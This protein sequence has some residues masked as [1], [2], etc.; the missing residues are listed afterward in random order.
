MRVPFGTGGARPK[1]WLRSTTYVIAVVAT[2]AF[3]AACGSDDGDDSGDSKGSS[4][5]SVDA[6]AL[7]AADWSVPGGDAGQSFHSTLDEIS[8]T[9]V[10]DLKGDWKAD[11][12]SGTEA[13]FSHETNINAIDGKLYVTTGENDV[14][15]YDGKTGKQLWKVEGNLDP[16]IST[17]CCGWE[18]RGLG[19][20]G[21]DTLYTARIDGKVQALDLETGDVKW[22]QQVVDW[23]KDNATLIGAPLYY[24]GK[25]YVG[26]SGSEFQARGRLVALDAKT[27]DEEWTF[28]TTGDGKD[29][30]ADKTWEGDS[31]LIGGSGLWNKPSVDEELGLLIFGTSTSSPDV[32]GSERG[33]DNLYSNSIVAVDAETGKYKWH[34]QLVKHDIWDF[35]VSSPVV[36]FDAEID[37]ETVPAAA[38]APKMPWVYAVDRRTG[39]PIFPGELTDVPQSAENKT[40]KQ[41]WVPTTE[42]LMPLKITDTQF[43]AL[44]DQIRQSTA[45]KNAA[46]IKINRP[47]GT[48]AATVFPAHDTTTATVM[49][50]APHGGTTWAPM[51]FS[52]DTQMLYVCGQEGWGWA[53]M[54]ENT[55]FTEGAF[56]IGGGLGGLGFNQAGYVKAL[57]ANTNEVKWTYRTVGADAKP[58]SCYSGTMNTAGGLVF[59][60]KNDGHLVALDAKTGKELWKFQTGA[61]V[62]ATATAFE[63]DGEQKIAVVAGGNSLAA[64]THGDNLWVFSL[65]G[66]LEQLDGLETAGKGE[67]HAGQESADPEVQESDSE[68]QND[69]AAEN[70]G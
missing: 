5:A 48:P 18:S 23:K 9:N 15:A 35:T 2:A 56:G 26:N 30:V 58:E 27:G 11:L 10:K 32:N 57:D 8:T 50:G 13:K 39:E 20:N 16:D 63:V 12:E 61:S 44:T 70:E 36:F 29:P 3:V 49:A 47:D 17:V 4:G 66:E 6:F 31:A 42:P 28:W 38:I 43:A 14:F 19:F 24:K 59:V 54:G 51:S 46:T 40:A 21:T 62:N 7:A 41:Q 69:D 33:G 55:P 60:G 64:T 65:S 22:E 1:R 25:V 45:I 52:P 34:F 67:E 37:G 68:Q 53:A